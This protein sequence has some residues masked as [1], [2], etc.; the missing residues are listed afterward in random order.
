MCVAAQSGWGYAA[1]NS[2]AGY[3]GGL[4]NL[5]LDEDESDS[6]Y[7]DDSEESEEA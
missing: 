1:T 4:D 3:T 5:G 7:S 6:E 2:G